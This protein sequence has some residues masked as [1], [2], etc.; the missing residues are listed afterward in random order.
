M[1]WIGEGEEP[2][3]GLSR[4]AEGRLRRDVPVDGEGSVIVK[5]LLS[6]W[7]LEKHDSELERVGQVKEDGWEEVEAGFTRLPRSGLRE[8]PGAGYGR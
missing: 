7:N 6:R 5:L 4:G 2:T 3:F 8:Q 1:L